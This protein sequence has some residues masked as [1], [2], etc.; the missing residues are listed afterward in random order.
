MGG[1]RSIRGAPMLTRL[2]AAS[3]GRSTPLKPAQ[4]TIGF[5]QKAI[6]IQQKTI[7]NTLVFLKFNFSA[8]LL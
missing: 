6:K 2:A 5:S 8:R 3:G 1:D 4:S 7:K